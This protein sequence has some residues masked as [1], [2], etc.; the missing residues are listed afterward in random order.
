M[1]SLL[2][3]TNSSAVNTLK[4][5]IQ[6]HLKARID[7]VADF[8]HGLKDVFEKRPSL[9]CIQEQINGVT[10]ESVARHIQML[11]GNSAPSFILMHENNNRIKPIKG[12]FDYLIDISQPSENIVK[13]F[14]NTLKSLLGADS[15]NNVYL[16]PDN[17]NGTPAERAA[18]IVPIESKEFADQ[19]VDDLLQDLDSL[20]SSDLEP[21][22]NETP[23]LSTDDVAAL[24]VEQ[25]K[26]ASVTTSDNIDD[27]LFLV[28]DNSSD[29]NSIN[30]EKTNGKG[31]NSKS[32]LIT[33][34]KAALE[35][36]TVE[37]ETPTKPTVKP[38]NAAVCAQP[39]E[40]KTSTE[41]STVSNSATNHITVD[42]AQ[43]A[44]ENITPV[45]EDK[46][47]VI[48]F[49]KP[50]EFTIS[51]SNKE[52]EE[53]P[54]DLLL[55]FEKN[56]RSQSASRSKL[57][58]SFVI[59]LVTVV[60][61]GWYIK[62]KKPNFIPWF[63]N[64]TAQTNK[65]IQVQN[66]QLANLPAKSQTPPIASNP[67]AV[68]P[69]KQISSTLAKKSKTVTNVKT[70]PISKNTNIPLS[71]ISDARL[72]KKYAIKRPGWERYVSVSEEF[73][74]FKSDSHIKAVQVLSRKGK[75]ISQ[76]RMNI[77]L[78]E[79]AGTDKFKTD[80]KEEKGGFAVSKGL[81]EGKGELLLYRKNN[82]IR[83][84][85]VSLD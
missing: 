44:N 79:I 72:D 61:G 58:I 80:G 39:A 8:D 19:L 5:A 33:A 56:F 75:S 7:I 24:L 27:S 83:A 16:K 46:K 78:K 21:S 54:E 1:V 32:A 9:V 23:Q 67:V 77:I 4:E 73:R 17:Q 62:S 29:A 22:K 84:F 59:I 71:F 25:S 12:L 37:H 14:L 64:K 47:S 26:A 60:A 52:T 6:P 28:S 65:N 3:I 30:N 74:I 10:G 48:N 20:G 31:D 34:E 76:K 36:T 2:F 50:S 45:K 57:Y 63:N 38:E 82:S 55:E 51:D 18:T 69:H 49:A 68:T 40:I 15:W 81:I 35:V 53:I 66:N 43:N 41:N 85:V 11:L 13:D 70:S 42:T